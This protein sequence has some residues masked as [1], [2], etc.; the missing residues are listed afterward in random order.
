M[1]VCVCIRAHVTTVCLCVCVCGLLCT[2]CVSVFMGHFRTAAHSPLAFRL[3]AR[4]VGGGLRVGGTLYVCATTDIT[5][6]DINRLANILTHTHAHTHEH[7]HLAH[8]TLSLSLAATRFIIALA[9]L[10][11]ALSVSL[12]LRTCPVLWVR[13]L[14]YRACRNRCRCIRCIMQLHLLR[15]LR[16][17]AS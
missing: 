4:R 10:M 2:V 9:L 14:R 11:L 7:T 8:I 1:C 6:I 13:A 16:A 5:F 17:R 15:H 3:D 12:S